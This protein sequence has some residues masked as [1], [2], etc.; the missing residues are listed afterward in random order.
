[1][2]TGPARSPTTV[3]KPAVFEPAVFQMP[4]HPARS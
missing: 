1:M 3:L 2:I 4:V